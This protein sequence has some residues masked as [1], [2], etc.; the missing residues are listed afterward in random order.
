MRYVVDI[1]NTIFKSEKIEKGT[2]CEYRIISCNFDLVNKINELYEKGN[3]IIIYTARHWNV[4]KQTIKHLQDY[5][6]KYTTVVM[7]KPV[8]DYYIDDKGITHEEFLKE[9]GNG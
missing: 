1:D 9:V 2:H 7:G 5:R 3:D 4:L 8:G 6:I